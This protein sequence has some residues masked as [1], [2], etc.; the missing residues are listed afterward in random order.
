[1][2]TDRRAVARLTP[3]RA[4]GMLALPQPD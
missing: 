1:M 4:Y 2:V 3:Q